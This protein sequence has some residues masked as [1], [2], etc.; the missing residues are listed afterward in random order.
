MNSNSKKDKKEVENKEIEKFLKK[1]KEKEELTVEIIQYNKI[2][3]RLLNE[4]QRAM[5]ASSIAGQKFN[6][7]RMLQIRVK[8]VERVLSSTIKFISQ[9]KLHLYMIDENLLGNENK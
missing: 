8:I 7:Q 5:V 4:I 9:N 1:G 2:F 3:D 6:S